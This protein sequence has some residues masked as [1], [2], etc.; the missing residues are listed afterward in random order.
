M[1]T[2][3]KELIGEIKLVPTPGRLAEIGVELSG[4][5]ANLAERYSNL[6]VEYPDRWTELRSV[7]KTD[8]ATD[9]AFSASPE[10]KEM[11]KLK[12]QLRYIEKAISS[13]N[14]LLRVK[15]GESRNMF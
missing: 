8:K 11:T 1:D 13:I 10:G 15:E 9:M 3:I 5:Y 4:Y 7:H 14:R 12:W 6:E 2:E